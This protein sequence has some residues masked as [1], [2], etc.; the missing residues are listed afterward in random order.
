MIAYILRASGS[1]QGCGGASVVSV[2]DVIADAAEAVGEG[3][4]FVGA[5]YV[6]EKVAN[7]G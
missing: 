7:F 1:E 5:Q 6:D 3:C 4:E 2:E